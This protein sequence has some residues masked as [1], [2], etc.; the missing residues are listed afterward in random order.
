MEQSG[1][2]ILQSMAVLVYQDKYQQS[3]MAQSLSNDIETLFDYQLS[4]SFTLLIQSCVYTS[5][6]QIQHTIHSSE[7]RSKL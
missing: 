5:I 2:L 3:K 4:S 1:W 7:M 6:H